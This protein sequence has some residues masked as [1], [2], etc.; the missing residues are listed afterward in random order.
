MEEDHPHLSIVEQC[1]L[2]G[3]SRSSYYY[4][5]TAVSTDEM[6]LR[7]IVDEIYTE[8]PHYGSRNITVVL[9]AMGYEVNR[10]RVQGIMRDMGIAGTQPGPHTSKPHPEHRKF[11]YLLRNMTITGPLQ[12]WSTDIT[13]IPLVNGYVYLCA[14]IDWFSRL[15]L[16]HELSNTLDSTFCIDALERAVERYGIPTIFNTDQGSQFTSQAFIDAV[17]S[18]G[19]QFSMDGRGRA[20]DN[21]FV[22]RLWRSLKYEEVYLHD[23]QTVKEARTRIQNYF[24]FY[25]KVRHHQGLGNR[26]P[27]EVHF[28]TEG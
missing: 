18:R 12:V 10:K 2:L 17:L 15:E 23:Y 21:V 4:A 8:R 9:R 1:D 24:E 14:V 6:K 13:Y 20:L 27:Y 19:M 22:E 16:A 11:P 25:N 26:T 3:L 7:V 5:P 28:G